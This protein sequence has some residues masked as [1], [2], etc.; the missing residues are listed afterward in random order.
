MPAIAMN[1][2]VD[3]GI[4]RVRF[5]RFQHERVFVERLERVGGTCFVAGEVDEDS[6][7]V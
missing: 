2:E 4:S 5:L 1:R 6:E 3:R 7:T